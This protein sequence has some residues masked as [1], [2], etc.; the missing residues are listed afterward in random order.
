MRRQALLHLVELERLD[1]RFDFLHG[2][3]PTAPAGTRAPRYVERI[4]G[5]KAVI[6]R[7]STLCDALDVALRACRRRRLVRPRADAPNTYAFSLC[8]E[9]S[10]PANSSSSSTRSPPVTAPA[11]PRQTSVPT[12]A[13]R[14]GERATASDLRAEQRRARPTP[15]APR[16]CRPELT[17]LDGEEPG[18]ERA[19][20]AADAVHA[21][22]VERVVVAAEHRLQ[23]ARRRSR[24]R[25]RRRRSRA[26]P[27]A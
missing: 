7:S 20:R 23:V 21:D 10:R 8:C 24:G 1:D 15:A 5:C 3:P 16:C 17:A 12:I 22:D 9:R 6:G 27:S 2:V 25:R 19:P 18:R 11:M 4:S 13:M 14:V 26:P